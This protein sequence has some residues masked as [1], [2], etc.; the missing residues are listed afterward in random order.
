[1]LAPSPAYVS[2]SLLVVRVATHSCAP[3]TPI[4]L[5]GAPWASVC[6]VGGKT[7]PLV[8]PRT[9]PHTPATPRTRAGTTP[10]SPPFLLHCIL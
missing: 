1:M 2:L 4:S 5:A 3:T 7:R 10:L 6:G 8:A 9:P